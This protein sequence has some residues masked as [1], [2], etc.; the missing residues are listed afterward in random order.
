MSAL[1][2]LQDLITELEHIAELF[3]DAEDAQD[4]ESA[5]EELESQ[6]GVINTILTEKKGQ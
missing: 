5:Y 3:E 4:V 1:S 6:S 2:N